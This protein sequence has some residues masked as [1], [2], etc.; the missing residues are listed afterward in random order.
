M[1]RARNYF[2]YQG[3]RG[4]GRVD[5]MGVFAKDECSPLLERLKNYAKPDLLRAARHT[6]H[7]LTMAMK[8]GMR[9]GGIDDIVIPPRKMHTR[10]L[11]L[12]QSKIR[13]N[14][15]KGPRGSLDYFFRNEK[16]FTPKTMLKTSSAAQKHNL[17]NAAG[18]QKVADGAVVGWLSRT[19][20]H[21]AAAV[22]NA[23]RGTMKGAKSIGSQPMSKKQQRLFAALGIRLKKSHVFRQP[24]ASFFD[25]FIRRRQAR[26]QK[27]MIDRLDFYVAEHEKKA[28]AGAGQ[29]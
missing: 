12:M 1:A 2:V 5:N 25:P 23:A 29:Q 7:W 14:K 19:S 4:G 18:Y 9:K 16:R 15:I 11:W 26:I 22:Q 8:D 10:N 27:T 20:P 28:K 17:V 3:F 21:W 6:A 24:T 13:S